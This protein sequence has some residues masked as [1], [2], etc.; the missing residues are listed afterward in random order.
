[1][2]KNVESKKAGKITLPKKDVVAIDNRAMPNDN[3][4][5]APVKKSVTMRQF[6]GT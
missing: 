4:I 6:F 2:K 3:R 5:V 1:M